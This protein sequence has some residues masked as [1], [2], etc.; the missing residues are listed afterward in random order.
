MEKEKDRLQPCYASYKMS[1]I[2]SELYGVILSVQ[3]KSN[4]TKLV[5]HCFIVQM[6]NG[7]NCTAKATRGMLFTC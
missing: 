3:I 5:G 6:A 2:N 7:P 4:A 1:R